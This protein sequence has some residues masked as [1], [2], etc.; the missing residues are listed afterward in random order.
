MHLLISGISDTVG[1]LHGLVMLDP[2]QPIG[3]AQS[4]TRLVFGMDY[5][6]GWCTCTC[7]GAPGVT[8]TTCSCRI[9]F[10]V[11]FYW[12]FLFFICGDEAKLERYF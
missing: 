3:Q 7:S 8:L 11:T 2:S 4:P 1:L 12:S 10:N 9:F 5:P 6:L